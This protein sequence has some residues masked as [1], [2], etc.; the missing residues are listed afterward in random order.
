MVHHLP[1]APDG[2]DYWR[3]PAVAAGVPVVGAACFECDLL[4]EG[5]VEA[6]ES[7]AE[8]WVPTAFNLR[9]F[10]AA[11]VDPDRLHAIPYPVDTDV[12]APD[13]R[14]RAAGAPVTFCSVFEWTWRKG[15]DVLLRAWAREF[16]GS[17]DVRLRLLTYRGAGAL[18]DG[19]I[20]DQATRCIRAAGSDL[21]TVADI[22]LILDPLSEDGLIELYRSA[23]A[24]VLP[25]RGEGAGMPV[26][27]AMACGTPAIATGWGGHEELMDPELSFPVEV[28]TLVEAAPELVLDNPLYRGL[29][30]AE[31]DEMSL[32]RA[33]RSVAEDPAA[34]RRR[35][36]RGRTVVEERFSIPSAGRALADR[37]DA[38]TAP[39]RS[40]VVA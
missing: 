28:E 22:E 40:R 18:G 35:A 27:E 15:W 9:T 34:A 38:L 21:D 20:V 8:V 5:W 24:F 30:L 19:D 10:A 36:A 3:E 37:V 31:P 2:T 13:G 26:I 25:T 29:R 1:R 14:E 11:G 32:R 23:D 17:E 6:A 12:F 4:P 7:V 16:D 33:L 39:P